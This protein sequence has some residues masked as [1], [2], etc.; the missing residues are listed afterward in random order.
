M[1]I[2][3]FMTNAVVKPQ[4]FDKDGLPKKPPFLAITFKADLDGLTDKELGELLTLSAAGD[5]LEITVEARQLRFDTSEENGS[6]PKIPTVEEVNAKVA[7]LQEMDEY[8]GWSL[9]DLS[10]KAREILQGDVSF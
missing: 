4:T 1:K 7:E 3:G 5:E 6:N 2:N 10:V 8:K 9:V